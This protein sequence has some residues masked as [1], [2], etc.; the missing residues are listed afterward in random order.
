MRTLQPSAVV[1]NCSKGVRWNVEETLSANTDFM[2]SVMERWMTF[3]IRMSGIAWSV[4]E[5]YFIPSLTRGKL[6]KLWIQLC[7]A[8]KGFESSWRYCLMRVHSRSSKNAVSLDGLKVGSFIYLQS[9]LVSSLVFT[10]KPEKCQQVS[11]PAV[12]LLNA[13]NKF[14]RVITVG[15]VMF[16]RWEEGRG[17][18]TSVAASTMPSYEHGSNVGQFGKILKSPEEDG[19][20]W[21]QSEGGWMGREGP[22]KGEDRMGTGGTWWRPVSSSDR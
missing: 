15:G 14:S 11:R 3:L 7:C 6:N 21:N 8:R 19:F 4:S 9:R 12:G 22:A 10:V 16:M 2:I 13:E 20:V 1:Q 5:V 17:P 18:W